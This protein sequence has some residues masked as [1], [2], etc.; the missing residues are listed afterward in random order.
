MVVAIWAT[1]MAAD[2]R[3]LLVTVVYLLPGIA[4]LFEELTTPWYRLSLLSGVY[5][6]VIGLLVLAMVTAAV[7]AGRQAERVL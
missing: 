2:A 6:G 5:W 4:A 7:R 1:A 3:W